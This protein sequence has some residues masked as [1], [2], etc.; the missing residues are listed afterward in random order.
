MGSR[1]E[2]MNE[3]MDYK[4]NG[5]D[6]IRRRYI[7]EL[8]DYTGNDTIIYFTS[9]GAPGINIENGDIQSFMTCMNDLNN[10]KLDLILHSQGG[11]TEAAE[12]IVQ[13]LRSKY[14]YISQLLHLNIFIKNNLFQNKKYQFFGITLSFQF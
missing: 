14:K 5:Q 4:N 3:I 1:T 12:Q 8:S 13:C 2:I 7:K 9:F 11:S 6:I 10:E